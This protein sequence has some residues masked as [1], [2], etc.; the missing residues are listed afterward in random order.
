MSRPGIASEERLDHKR[1]ILRIGR[2]FGAGGAVKLLNFVV[3]FY[4]VLLR[5]RRTPVD[6]INCH[7]LAVLPLCFFLKWFHHCDLVYDTHELETE[8]FG[9]FGIRKFVYKLLE[10]AA[11]RQF[12]MIIV[13][14]EEIKNWYEQAYGLGNI[15]LI[16]NLPEPIA[17]A[18]PD[19]NFK[20]FR[21]RFSIVDGAI[22]FLY[23]G[24]FGPGRGIE[25]ILNAFKR[26]DERHHVVFLGFGK[27]EPIIR[28]AA[29][30]FPNIH[31]HPAVPRNSVYLYTQSAD[32]GLSLIEP[33][34]LSY[35]YSMPNK[36]FQYISCGLPVIV[37]NMKSMKAFVESN[38]CGWST[39]LQEAAFVSVV[40]EITAAELMSIRKALIT[41]TD[42]YSW[43]KQ[44]VR[45]RQFYQAAFQ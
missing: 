11:I 42:G 24:V 16:Y 31:L 30:N 7:S 27:L 29:S 17:I 20:P 40:K 43:E 25:F 15:R 22:I 14:S 35:E 1:V 3:W 37:S 2:R 39:P 23:Q 4:Q 8:R 21:E 32:V 38:G 33:S 45:L 19:E 36:V 5:F 44:G 13:V 18:G 41:V 6:V 9:L 10:R 12:K 28:D 26:L 34:C